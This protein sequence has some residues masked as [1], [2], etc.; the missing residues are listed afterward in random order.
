MKTI[1]IV[2]CQLNVVAHICRSC[3][4]RTRHKFAQTTYEEHQELLV[5][6]LFGCGWESLN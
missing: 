1:R 5:L 4:K 6:F 2:H 3:S